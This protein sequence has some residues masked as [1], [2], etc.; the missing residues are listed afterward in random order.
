VNAFT[1]RIGEGSGFPDEPFLPELA[2]EVLKPG[3]SVPPL[4]RLICALQTAS[5]PEADATVIENERAPG[6]GY[7]RGISFNRDVA[8]AARLEEHPQ[9]VLLAQSLLKRIKFPDDTR[10]PAIIDL[11]DMFKRANGGTAVVKALTPM[12]WQAL[13]EHAR[14]KQA[15]GIRI[16]LPRFINEAN[17]P[18]ALQ[19]INNISAGSRNLDG[20]SVSI[21]AGPPLRD[22]NKVVIDGKLVIDFLRLSAPAPAIGLRVKEAEGTTGV[23]VWAPHGVV[24]RAE[25]NSLVEG[26][27]S[28]EVR[29]PAGPGA[30]SLLTEPEPLLYEEA[31][32]A[33]A[34]SGA[35]DGGAAVSSPFK[36]TESKR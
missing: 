36:W 22:Q 30:A 6:F 25:Y 17:G 16:L 26:V 33:R 10:M 27:K 5:H 13:I 31:Q 7:E 3:A 18:A 15:P 19:V 34:P 8:S 4:V 9:R 35:S 2:G 32:P 21:S 12:A 24:V 11:Q 23:E 28:M 14:S 1:K 20:V 29:R